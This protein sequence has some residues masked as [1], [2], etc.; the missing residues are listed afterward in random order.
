MKTVVLLSGGLDS[1]TALALMLSR[2][3]EVR[4]LSITY[5]STHE[6]RE[7]ASAAQ[8]CAYFGCT[9]QVVGL[10]PSVFRGGY[11]ALLGES[12]IPDAEYQDV[13]T[14]GPS[15][16]VV[17]FRNSNLISIAVS[18]AHANGMEK[19][20][21]S[22]HA[23]DHAHWAYPD[24]SPEFVGAM[25]TAVYVGTMGEVRLVAPF[26]WMTKTEIVELA[27]ELKAPLHLTRSCYRDQEFACGT[28]PTCIE[29]VKAFREAGYIDPIFYSDFPDDGLYILELR[30]FPCI[31]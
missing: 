26:I 1:T 28:C 13:E 4:A 30:Q 14:E 17:P 8:V 16:T 27:A 29:R 15:P 31:Q 10:P 6:M 12:E 22:G 23:T 3:D 11:S 20:V 21:F 25:T 19:V 24:C 9:H 5:G 2:G 18:I 7:L